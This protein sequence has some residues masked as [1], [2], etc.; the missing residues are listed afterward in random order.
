MRQRKTNNAGSQCEK[1]TTLVNNNAKRNDCDDVCCTRYKRRTNAMCQAQKTNNAELTTSVHFIISFIFTSFHHV[2]CVL[3]FSSWLKDKFEF[4]YALTRHQEDP[5]FHCIFF[6]T[7]HRHHRHREHRHRE[8]RYQRDAAVVH[9]SSSPSFSSSLT[10][11][12]RQT[13]NAS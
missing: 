13:N 11:A 12:Q 4:V 9:R 5:L 7:N 6:H 1:L 10:R 8:H 2:F 3:F